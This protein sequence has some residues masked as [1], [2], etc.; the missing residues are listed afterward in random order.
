MT[1]FYKFISNKHDGIFIVNPRHIMF[2]VQS[3]SFGCTRDIQEISSLNVK[4]YLARIS[5]TNNNALLYDAN[6]L[7]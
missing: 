4:K 1:S 6:C 5:N 2:R 7:S 3:T